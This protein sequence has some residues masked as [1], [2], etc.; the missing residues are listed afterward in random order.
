MFVLIRSMEVDRMKIQG[1]NSTWICKKLWRKKE[2]KDLNPQAYIN[3]G[4]NQFSILSPDDQLTISY[5]QE[6][7]EKN[8]S[9]LETL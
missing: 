1:A 3:Q 9:R 5:L 6:E 8:Y 7:S 4:K 2:A